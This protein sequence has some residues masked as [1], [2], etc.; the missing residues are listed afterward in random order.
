MK[1]SDF[2]L[3]IMDQIK[4]RYTASR[5]FLWIW[6]VVNQDGAEVFT[7][8]QDTCEIQAEHLNKVFELG[9]QLGRVAGLH[10]VREELGIKD[11]RE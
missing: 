2:N 6:Q 8:L 3:T 7:G 1:Y 9:Y 4:V 5:K 10:Q 11:W